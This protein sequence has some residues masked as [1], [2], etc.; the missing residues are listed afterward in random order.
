M[1]NDSYFHQLKY[2]DFLRSLMHI[3]HWKKN[4]TILSIG[5]FEKQKVVLQNLY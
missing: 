5:Q 3:Y 4:T 1:K 2:A